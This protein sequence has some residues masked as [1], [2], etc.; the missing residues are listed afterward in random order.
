VAGLTEEIDEGEGLGCVGEVEGYGEAMPGIAGDFEGFEIFEVSGA[1]CG[2]HGFSLAVLGWDWRVR[3]G[4]SPRRVALRLLFGSNKRVQ[5]E[6]KRSSERTKVNCN[7]CLW[8]WDRRQEYVLGSAFNFL[9]SLWVRVEELIAGPGVRRVH[10]SR[11]TRGLIML[12]MRDEYFANLH[13]SA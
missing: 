13:E 7:R 8:T 4:L 9:Q 10:A 1:L 2:G 5:R 6:P 3:F 12:G 11:Q